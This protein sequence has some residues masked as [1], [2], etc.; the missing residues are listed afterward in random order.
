MLSPEESLEIAELLYPNVTETLLDMESLF[1]QRKENFVTR[2]A[3]SPTWFLHIWALYMTLISTQL[4]YQNRGVFF[5]R[6]ED[7]DTKRETE[8]GVT[9]IL[10][11]LAR[12][13]V[14]IDEGA[15][16]ENMS[17]VGNYGPYTQSKRVRFYHIFAK[18]IVQKW[19]AYPCFLTE[20]E[21]EEIRNS[22]SAIGKVPWVYGNYSPWRSESF[23]NI[24]LRILSGDPYVLRFRAPWVIG[25]RV[26]VYDEIRWKIE[27]DDNFHDIVLLKN[28][29]I[30]TYHFAHFVDD[31]L[32]GTTH[33]LR[34]E[35]WLPS[36]PLHY[37]LFR[38]F[39]I[40]V[41]KYAHTAQLMKIDNGNKRKLSK[42]KD[43]EADVTYF[44]ENGYPVEAIKNYLCGILDSGFEAWKAEHM[45]IPYSEYIFD[46]SRMPKSWA[47]FDLRK[48]DSVSN[49]YLTHLSNEN[50]FDAILVWAQE[51]RPL[52]Y[53]KILTHKEL[54]FKAI[55]IQRGTDRDPKKFSKLSDVESY[56]VPFLSE[57]FENQKSLRRE[58][59]LPVSKEQVWEIV[60]EYSNA[61]DINMNGTDWLVWMKDLASKFKFARDGAE[62]KLWG[63]AGK[64]WDFAMIIRIAITG[65]TNSPDLYETMQ[66]LGM[67]EVKK[68]LS[69]FIKEFK[70]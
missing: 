36:L 21:V 24:K 66:V 18:H 57:F 62:F 48:L 22:Q 37:Q 26:T 23:E 44:F 46:F 51:F 6:I 54:C 7:T 20:S 31:H 35:E 12:F 10:T 67:T 32:M 43:S 70:S 47:L 63:Y 33:V 59:V 29:G 2:L 13:G 60:S 45:D 55:S 27:M 8:S 64:F 40:P 42:R 52:L 53:Q 14:K 15:I 4:V 19:L 58:I 68:R 11:G 25:A 1:P 28:N 38:A 69:D 61:F 50:L 16:G 41:L 65:S 49:I 56:L 9:D 34:A 3:P 39:N 5:L 17:E 30:P